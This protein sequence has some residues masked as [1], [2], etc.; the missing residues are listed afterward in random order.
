MIY[1]V[2]ASA[3]RDGDGSE[4]RPFKHIQDAAKLAL[5]GDEVLVKPGIYR[6][7]VAPKNAG[8]KENIKD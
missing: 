5:P 3:F 2:D 6:E 1:Y 4:N 7:H 8:T